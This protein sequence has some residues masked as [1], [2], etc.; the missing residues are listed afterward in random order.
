MKMFAVIAAGADVRNGILA[1]FLEES[2]A[3]SYIEQLSDDDPDA[4]YE[5]VPVSVVVTPEV[6]A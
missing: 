4:D 1:A 2:W 3:D 5:T 6:T